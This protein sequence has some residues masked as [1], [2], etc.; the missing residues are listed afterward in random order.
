MY[1]LVVYYVLRAPPQFGEANSHIVFVIL[2]L[3]NNFFCFYLPHL[4]SKKKRKHSFFYTHSLMVCLSL[5]TT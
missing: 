5:E 4:Q 1:F 2:V 3:S